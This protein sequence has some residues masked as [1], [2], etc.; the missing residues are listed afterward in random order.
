VLV[1]EGELRGQRVLEVGCGTG[2][3]AA[4]LAER[5][6]CKVWAVDAEPAMV[7]IARE[8]LPRGAQAKV[9][10]AE[11]LPFK[12]GW[13]D[14]AVMRLVLHH[15]DRERA[16]PELAR[17]LGSEGRLVI[18]TLDPAEFP[19]R[20]YSEL[21]PET[22]APDQERFV[23]P[24]TLAAELRDAGFAGVRLV[25]HRQIER[26]SREELVER[27]EGRFISTLEW[28]SDGRLAEAAATA[29]RELPD[30][31][32]AHLKWVVAVAHR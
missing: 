19:S 30:E 22:I 20:W 2:R 29:R 21:F 8:R 17:V 12:D 16:L 24:A 4:A 27:L 9:A 7:E 23:A 3:L 18:A 1:R 28:V 25:E 31:I 32:E 14:R 15:L 26:W 13:F 6:L 10:S 5:E 11:A